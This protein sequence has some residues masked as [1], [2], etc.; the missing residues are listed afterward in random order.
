MTRKFLYVLWQLNNSKIFFYQLAPDTAK[1]EL[2]LVGVAAMFVAGKYEEM[3]CTEI[4]DFVYITDKAYSKLQIRQ[5]ETKMLH[6]L[7]FYLSYPLPLHF[8]RR[9]SKAAQVGILKFIFYMNLHLLISNITMLPAYW[10]S[11]K[12]SLLRESM[13]GYRSTLVNVF[14]LNDSDTL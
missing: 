5:M 11:H 13:I 7:D 8:L 4:G 2:Q 10:V 6:T 1:E 14:Q 12:T 9:N 3:Y